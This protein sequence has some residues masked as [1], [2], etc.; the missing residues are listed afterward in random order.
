MIKLMNMIMDITKA[1]IIMINNQNN[2]LYIKYIV[3]DIIFYSWGIGVEIYS[4]TTV[5]GIDSKLGGKS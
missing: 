1:V 5:A 4:I 2:T 3:D